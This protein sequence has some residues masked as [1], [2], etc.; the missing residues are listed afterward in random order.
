MK[1]NLSSFGYRNSSH[2][3]KIKKSFKRGLPSG[4][5]CFIIPPIS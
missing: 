4:F 2:M 3:K 1:T 5:R